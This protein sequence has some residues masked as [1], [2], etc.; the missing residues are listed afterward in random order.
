MYRIDEFHPQLDDSCWRRAAMA[1]GIIS[2]RNPE[3]C[4]SLQ[5]RC[6]VLRRLASRP[7]ADVTSTRV[8]PLPN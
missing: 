1:C 7:H 8:S 6:E 2:Y 5:P 3:C 4:N